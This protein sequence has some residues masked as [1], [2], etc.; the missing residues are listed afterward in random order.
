MESLLEAIQRLRARGY[1]LSF[2]A[3]DGKLRCIESDELV[4]PER[5]VVDEI[6]RLED[7]SNPSEQ[8]MLLGLRLP[9]EDRR[10]TWTV[11]FGPNMAP[12]NAQIIQRLGVA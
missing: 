12:A 4:D 7:D 5:V 1:E 8:S 11:V 3:E 10:G 9:T 6:V 2:H